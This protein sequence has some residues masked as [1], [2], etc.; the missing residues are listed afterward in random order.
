MHELV[1]QF[2]RVGVSSKV[3]SVVAVEYIYIPVVDVVNGQ[4]PGGIG[5][6]IISVNWGLI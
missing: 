2:F 4:Q 5:F 6:L 1:F 3:Y